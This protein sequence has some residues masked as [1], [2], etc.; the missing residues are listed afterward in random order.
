MYQA[1]RFFFK[2][3]QMFIIYESAKDRK[4]QALFSWVQ[5]ASSCNIFNQIVL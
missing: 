2:V 3:L 5:N 1:M 4:L